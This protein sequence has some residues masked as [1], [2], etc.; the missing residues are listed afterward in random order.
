MLNNLTRIIV[1][2]EAHNPKHGI[3]SRPFCTNE[4]GEKK[5][6]FIFKLGKNVCC[7]SQIVQVYHLN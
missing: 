7:F 2:N 1:V 6:N 4:I 5:V 3:S